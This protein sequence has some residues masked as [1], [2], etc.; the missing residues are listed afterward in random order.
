M[1]LARRSLATDR[2]V[3]HPERTSGRLNGQ[4]VL[5]NEGLVSA[6]GTEK[7]I[8]AEWADQDL[9]LNKLQIHLQCPAKEIRVPCQPRR[10]HPSLIGPEVSAWDSAQ[11][12]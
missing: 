5:D 6:R 4:Q 12:R 7:Q 3:G 10:Q 9:L 1:E 2:R 11:G 8:C